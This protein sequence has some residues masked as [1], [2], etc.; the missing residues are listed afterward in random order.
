MKSSGRPDEDKMALLEL[1]GAV[2]LP[3]VARSEAFGVALLEGAMSNLPLISTQI[4]TGTTYVNLDTETG[5]VVRAR[6]SFALRNAMQWIWDRPTEAG[7]MGERAAARYLDLFTAQ[8]MM[9]K[10]CEVYQSAVGG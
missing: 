4:G 6:D 8:R 1:A 3:S 9:E 2:V 5:R 10:Y 7:R